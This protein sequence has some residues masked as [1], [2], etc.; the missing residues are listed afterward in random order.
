MKINRKRREDKYKK[1]KG[2]GKEDEEEDLNKMIFKPSGP[3]GR[4]WGQ[5]REFNE[6]EIKMFLEKKEILE[7]KNL[8]MEIRN[9]KHKIGKKRAEKVTY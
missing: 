2:K 4:F 8:E 3:D 5:F 9:K 1:K 7:H 6:E